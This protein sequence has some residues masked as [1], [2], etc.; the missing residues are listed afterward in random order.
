[1]VERG[2]GE[3]ESERERVDGGVLRVCVW[4][5]MN[6]CSGLSSFLYKDTNPIMGVPPSW[7]HLT[8]ITSSQIASHRG[9]E[10]PMYDFVGDTNIQSMTGEVS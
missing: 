8:L 3:K 4:A 5:S 1:M 6:E 7:P 9:L 2:L 10:V